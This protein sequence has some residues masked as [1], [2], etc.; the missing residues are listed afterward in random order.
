MAKEE[1]GLTTEYQ[2]GFKDP[3]RSVFKSEA[4]LS[5]EV[6]ATISE[7]KGEPGWMRD[8]RLRALEIFWEKPL[9]T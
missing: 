6:V 1:L 8:L 5:R 9:P 7:M 4:G 3:D 2:Y